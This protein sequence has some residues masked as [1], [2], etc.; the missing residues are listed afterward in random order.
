MKIA[1]SG[2]W[3]SYFILTNDIDCSGA[4]W[5]LGNPK[6]IGDESTPFTG[7][8]D[9]QG[10]AISNITYIPGNNSDSYYGFFGNIGAGGNIYNLNLES[11]TIQENPLNFGSYFGI[12]CGLNIGTITNCSSSGYV[13][14]SGLDG[15]FCGVN[16][17]G[18]ISHCHSQANVTGSSW[19]GGF[20]G[21]NHPGTISYCS[22]KGTVIGG[23]LSSNIGGFCG[24][25]RV[26]ESS[27]PIQ[28][29]SLIVYS[30]SNCDVIGDDKVGD[31]CGNIFRSSI[32]NCYCIGDVT[33]GDR[34][35]GFIGEF[36]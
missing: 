17:N 7:N 35:G 32:S 36:N 12:L 30:Y 25:H 28:I 14:G 27:G 18:T 33:G 11:I 29:P 6:P 22:S 15:G 13:N 19:V 34:V 4:T 24:E 10:Y 16:S 9:G 8:F 5:S 3:G 23:E 21:Q 2:D 31:F 20:C 1:N 26:V